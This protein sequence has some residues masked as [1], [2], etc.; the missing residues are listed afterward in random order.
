MARDPSPSSA[1]A[2]D[3]EGAFVPPEF[4]VTGNT[5][6]VSSAGAPATLTPRAGKAATLGAAPCGTRAGA[7]GLLGGT[8]ALVRLGLPVVHLA[9][10]AACC[11]D[12][13]S[14]SPSSSVFL[15]CELA[16]FNMLKVP[17]WPWWVAGT[18]AAGG[19]AE[20]WAQRP[21]ASPPR[22]TCPC[23]APAHRVDPRTPPCF[24]GSEAGPPRKGDALPGP[25][26]RCEWRRD[27]PEQPAWRTIN[28]VRDHKLK[29]FRE[30]PLA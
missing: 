11:L 3:P 10:G 21:P 6:Q 22:A 24:R 8:P 27:P 9:L 18:P 12:A 16:G 1:S 14:S 13:C 19:G 7:G 15:E 25:P 26:P 29:H 4:D 5:F 30:N 2:D 20:E 23:E 17:R 28:H